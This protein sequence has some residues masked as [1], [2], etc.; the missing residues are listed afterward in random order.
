[1]TFLLSEDKALRK[2][3]E[4]ITVADQKA[5]G[6]ETPRPVSVWFGQPDQEIRAQTYPY[7]IIDMIDVQRDPSRE[8]R[9]KVK[10][11]YI[12]DPET[13]ADVEWDADLN[14]WRIDLPI[15]VNIDYQLTTFSRHPRHDRELLARLMA[16]VL[17]MRFGVLEL[18]D[19]T[20][21]RLDVLDIS[22]RDVVEQSRRLFMNAITVRVSSELLQGTLT[23]LY[24][25]LEVHMDDVDE[26]RVGGTGRTP[27]YVSP[28]TFTITAD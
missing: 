19:G 20:V 5:D 7:I 3:L 10:P 4:G 22:K 1:M 12:S 9:G 18:D 14:D 17:P 26:S 21:R 16:D 25:V 27:G 24:K 15:P 6:E 23:T 8:M 28:G 13:I 11:A 2:K